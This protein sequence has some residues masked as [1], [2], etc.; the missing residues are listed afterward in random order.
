MEDNKIQWDASM[1][2]SLKNANG[3]VSDQSLGYQYTIQTTTFI[4]ARVLEQ[5]FY[6]VPMADYVP[7]EVGTGAYLEDIKTNV[8]Y[9]LA[10]SFEAGIQDTASGP[11]QVAQVSVATAPKTAKI[12]TW[13]Y[14]YQYSVPE[15]EKA[16][17]SNNWNV[18]EGKMRALKRRFDLGLQKVAFLGLRSDAG[19]PGLLSNTEVTVDSA[20]TITKYISSMSAIEFSTFVQ[21]ILGV[22]F[23]NA[24]YTVLP[25]TFLMPMQDFL[26]LTAPVSPDFPVVNKL[27]YLEDA[28][29]RAT[30]NPN[31]KIRATAYNDQTNNVGVWAVAGTNRYV[32]YRND[33]DTVK[34]D[35]PVSF[36]LNPAATADNFHWNGVGVAQFTGAVVY[37]APEVMYFDW[38][39]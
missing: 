29:K 10:G 14:G 21:K 30:M 13:A 24:G 5:K 2:K 6:T 16:L 31:F 3:A 37:R 12:K 17:A 35:L 38:A 4:R 25:D 26:G 23:A 8:Q 22:Y 32:L 20:T 27:A 19:V 18:I 34:M 15:V 39:A 9:D 36:V 7:I 33:P 11:T 1:V 28:F